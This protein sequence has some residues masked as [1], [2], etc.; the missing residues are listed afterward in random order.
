VADQIIQRQTPN[1]EVENPLVFPGITMDAK[2]NGEF[3]RNSISQTLST[4]IN[5]LN[6]ELKVEDQIYLIFPMDGSFIILFEFLKLARKVIS[7]EDFAKIVPVYSAKDF[8]DDGKKK[9][10]LSTLVPQGKK[11]KIIDDIL[12]SGESSDLIKEEGE[13][14]DENCEII[15]LTIK[16]SSKYNPNNS[17]YN[18][19]IFQDKWVASGWGMNSGKFGEAVIKK[20]ISDKKVKEDVDIEALTALHNDIDLYERICGNSYFIEDEE[21]VH[22]WRFSEKVC[23]MYL[24]MLQL[25]C[26]Y[27]GYELEEIVGMLRT[28][29]LLKPKDKFNALEA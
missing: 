2:V 18:P 10:V 7:P 5:N 22:S 11:V 24:D 1:E 23:Q 27:E 25:N 6:E 16:R 12:D 9:Y 17:L 20:G 3:Q 28:I 13:I 15:P 14:S 4:F 8:G 26:M 29:Q 21:M 19:Y